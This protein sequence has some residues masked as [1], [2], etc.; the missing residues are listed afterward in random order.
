MVIENKKD[1]VNDFGELLSKYAYR[2]N[3]KS[4]RYFTGENGS[5]FIEI[6]FNDGFQ[7]NLSVTGDSILAIV[8]DIY[9]KLR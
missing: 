5:E 6:S 7:K 4:M 3:I 1:F 8:H 9:L 2:L